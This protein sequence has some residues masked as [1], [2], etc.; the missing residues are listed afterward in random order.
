MDVKLET[1]KYK[2]A[3]ASDLIIYLSSVLTYNMTKEQAS[4]FL[5]SAMETW[6]GRVEKN[7]NM[8]HKQNI[9]AYKAQN[10]TDDPDDVIDILVQVHSTMPTMLREEFISEMLNVFQTMV[11]DHKTE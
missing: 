6:S 9:E 3:L 10:L 1:E 7:L 2:L 8:I 5:G 11:V 4:Q